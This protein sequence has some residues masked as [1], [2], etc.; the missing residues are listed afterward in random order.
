M[1]KN[2]QGPENIQSLRENTNA[3]TGACAK[4]LEQVVKTVVFLLD[5][6]MT[7]PVD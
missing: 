7:E 4:W 3:A 1:I 6:S 5:I 2:K